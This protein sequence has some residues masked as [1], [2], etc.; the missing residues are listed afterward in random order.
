M[1][2]VIHKYSIIHFERS[3]GGEIV[4]KTALYVSLRAGP[5]TD[6]FANAWCAVPLAPAPSVLAVNRVRT[7]GA[8]R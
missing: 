4:Y 3:R 8:Q 2:Q 5:V 1:V 6:A 7:T